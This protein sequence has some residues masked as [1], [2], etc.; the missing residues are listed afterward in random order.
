M[1]YIISLICIFMFA[2]GAFA[3]DA[4]PTASVWDDPMLTFY[5][6]VGFIFI[7]AILVLLVAAYMLRVLNYMNQQAARERAERLGI[8]Y[9]PE[10]SMWE[11]LWQQSNDFVPV[12][13]E[14]SIT[15]AHSYDGIKELDNHLPPWWTGLF[16]VTIIFGVGY[17]LFYHVF[18]TLPSQKAE[19]DNEVAIAQEQLKKL[20]AANPVAAIDENNVEATTDALALAE[21]KQIFLNTCAS[22][23]RKD[24]GGDIGP[25]LTDDY[26]KHG[27]GIKDIFKTVRHGVQGTNMIAWEGVI[28]PE[29][30]KNVSSYVL[31]LRGT[32]PPNAKKPEGNLLK[33][34]S[35]PDAKADSVKTQ[36]S[37]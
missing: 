28:S 27:G 30:M 12:E 4:A 5:L 9:V 21:G 7:L 20:Q 8:K 36:A 18:D 33:P 13:K 11:K 23:H 22:C 16:V 32:N 25:N 35:K 3:Q 31:S 15:F 26:W 6:V 34:E 24:G 37:L 10:P 2:T 17:L 29:K 1:K 14:E 19:Y